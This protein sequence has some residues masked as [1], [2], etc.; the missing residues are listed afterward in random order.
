MAPERFQAEHRH[1]PAGADA[2]AVRARGADAGRRSDL[3]LPSPPGPR[4]DLQRPAQADAGDAARRLRSLGRQDQRRARPR[5]RVRGDPRLPPRAGAAL[6]R[7]AR[8]ARR[9]RRARSAAT[10]RGASRRPAGARSR[11]ATCMPLRTCCAAPSR[12]SP[13]PIR[14]AC[15]SFPS[16]AKCCSRSASSPTRAPRSTRRSPRPTRARPAHQGVGRARPPAPAPAQRRAGQAGA[17]PRSRCTDETIPALERERAHGELAQGVA[18]GGARAAEQRPVRRGGGEH[19]EGRQVRAARRR[20]AAGLA[21]RARPDAERAL[22]A[23]AGARGD[24]A[25]R[26]ADRRRPRRP[27]GAEPDRLQDR[28]AACDERRF[29]EGA[30]DVRAGARGAARP[31]AGRARRFGLARP[32]RGRAARRRSGRRRARGP[33]RLRDAREDGRDLLPLDDGGDAARARFASK[34][35][36][37][38]RWS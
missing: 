3:P 36:T 19:R 18:A 25:L 33:P 26:G 22:R 6:P 4:H 38:R 24:R 13:R 32:G 1:P 30:R 16:S 14:S 15:R 35:A 11:A 2:Q 9:E 34:A 28:A 23:D 7:R 5:P 37:P 31:G 20:P 17:T 10:A 21:Q 29:R 12:C 8:A 27:P